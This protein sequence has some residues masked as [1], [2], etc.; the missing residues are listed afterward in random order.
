MHV[1]PDYYTA[2][3]WNRLM[4][5]KVLSAEVFETHYKNKTEAQTPQYVEDSIRV[6]A[7]CTHRWFLEKHAISKR[8][9]ITLAFIN[10]STHVYHTINM[11]GLNLG[12]RAEYVL[13]SPRR[14]DQHLGLHSYH[15]QLNGKT[16]RVL[17]HQ[18]PV[19]PPNWIFDR[20]KKLVL[21]PLSYGYIV[22]PEAKN[23]VCVTPPI[24]GPGY[25]PSA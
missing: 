14:K 3:L 2:L 4:G 17:D 21:P 11:T 20:S 16:L 9:S 5:R 1:N 22:F 6:Y 24:P 8:G 10:L 25:P 18:I 23:P 12:I 15:V 19:L 7:H 13:Q